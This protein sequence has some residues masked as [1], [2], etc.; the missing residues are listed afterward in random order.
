MTKRLISKG[1]KKGTKL[2]EHC[3]NI[4]KGSDAVLSYEDSDDDTNGLAPIDIEMGTVLG[5]TF[6]SEEQLDEQDIEDYTSE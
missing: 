3:L 6:V 5:G 2:Q 1:I 4:G